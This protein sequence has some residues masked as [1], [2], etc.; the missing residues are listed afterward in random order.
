M[1]EHL[2]SPLGVAQPPESIAE[3]VTAY[4]EARGAR[5]RDLGA[6]VPR[7]L[8]EAVLPRLESAGLLAE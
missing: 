1:F 3:A 4:R 6:A 7:A 8:E 5:E 2:L